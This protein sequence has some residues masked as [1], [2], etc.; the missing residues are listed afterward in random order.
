MEA[1]GIGALD[2]KGGKDQ[3]RRAGTHNISGEKERAKSVVS[4]FLSFFYE[5]HFVQP[6]F[7]TFST[8]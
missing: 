7:T 5:E 8:S 4:F 6:H 2:N 1:G 3:A